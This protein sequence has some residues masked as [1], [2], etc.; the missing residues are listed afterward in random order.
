MAAPNDIDL[1]VIGGGCAGLSLG[2]LLAKFGCRLNTLIIE[3]RKVYDNDRTW[4][5]WAGNEHP[6]DHLVRKSW[7]QWRFSDDAGGATQHVCDGL[8]YYCIPAANFYDE[9]LGLVGR[10]RRIR[11]SGGITAYEIREEGPRIRISTSA[12]EIK[13]KYVVDTRPSNL[14]PVEDEPMQQV[15]LGAEVVTERPVFDMDSVGLMEQMSVDSKG[16]RF[17]YRLPF[18]P[19]TALIEETRFAVRPVTESDLEL[20]LNESLT[21]LDTGFDV[22]RIESGRLPMTANCSSRP[23]AS[24][25][26]SAGVGGGAIRTSTGYAFSRIQHWASDCAKQL[27]AGGPPLR[28]RDEPYWRS[29]VDSLFLRVIRSQPEIAPRLFMAMAKQLSPETFVRFLSDDG[30]LADFVQVALTL[31]KRPFLREVFRRPSR[32]GA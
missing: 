30:Q 31:P 28:H 11:F 9:S 14:S 18:S 19:T 3:P 22:Q 5:F 24:P 7:R 25:V 15:F 21:Q 20:G 10:S 8:R 23:A 12:G 17:T 26:V 27:A 32:V 6:L 2:R 13:A 1:L 16:F 4:C 29:A